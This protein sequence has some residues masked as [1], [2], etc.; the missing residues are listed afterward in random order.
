[1]N[2]QRSRRG[3]ISS[4]NVLM[5]ILKKQPHDDSSSLLKNLLKEN[6]RK[7]KTS[8]RAQGIQTF[9]EKLSNVQLYPSNG[10]WHID[11]VTIDSNFDSGN[12][13]N[14]EMNENPISDED[15]IDRRQGRRPGQDFLTQKVSIQLV[16]N[17]RNRCRS[18]YLENTIF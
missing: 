5:D 15:S 1:M 17:Q 18:P 16:A 6:I 3:S 2:V 12:L 4:D 13:G 8:Q 11:D 7:G 9:L 14:V 10:L